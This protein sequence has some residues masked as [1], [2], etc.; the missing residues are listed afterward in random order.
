[1]WLHLQ[2][3]TVGKAARIKA[4]LYIFG[5]PGVVCSEWTPLT[6]KT[7]TITFKN[8]QLKCKCLQFPI[9]EVRAKTVHKSQGGT[10]DKVVFNYERGLDQQLVYVDLSRVT[11]IHGLHLT[12][13]KSDYMFHHWKASNNPKIKDLYTELTHLER[14]KLLT[15]TDRAQQFLQQVSS[16]DFTMT[17][18]NVQ[19]LASHSTDISTDLV[20]AFMDILAFMETWMDNDETVPVHGYKC[21]TQFK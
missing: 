6:H 9:V 21:I 7:A 4:R 18:L 5:N 17:T 8:K 2:P 20:L 15:I 14:H 13:L 10:F 12:N 3:N 11:S 19:S 16:E 1:V